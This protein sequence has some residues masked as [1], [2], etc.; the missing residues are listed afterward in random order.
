[1]SHPAELR[2]SRLLGLLMATLAAIGAAVSP[3]ASAQ[4][5]VKYIHTD[6]LGSVVVVTDQNRNVLER[7]EYEPYGA[8]LTPAVQDGPGYTGHVQDAATELTYMQQRYYDPLCG[9]FLSVDPVTAYDN[10]VS[11]FHRYRYSNNNPYKFTDPDG[12]RAVVR[13]GQIHIQPENPAMPSVTIPN[14]VGASGVGPDRMFFHD[15]TISTPASSNNPDAISGA[16]ANNPT[17]GVGDYASPQG[18]LNNVG[19]LPLQLDFGV[20][21]VRSFTVES[22]DPSKFTDITVNYTVSGAH[23]MHEGFVLQY[24]QILPSGQISN[25]SYG[26]GNAF[27][28]GNWNKS[29]WGPQVRQVWE[30]HHREINEAAKG[31]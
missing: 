17:P 10:P 19:H 18:T 12:R 2:K 11:Q 9:C 4:T 21:M 16:F 31:R 29:V 26:E 8:Q 25:I 30:A 24:G 23:A 5:V 13:D 22:P 6:A 3:L 27:Q 15:Y 14:T 7:R 28:Q 20:N 1:M